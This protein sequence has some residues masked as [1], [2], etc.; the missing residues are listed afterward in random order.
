MLVALAL[1]VVAAA[2]GGGGGSSATTSGQTPNASTSGLPAPEGIV[3]VLA[4]E[5]YTE[6]SWIVPFQKETGCQVAVRYLGPGDDTVQILSASS[7]DVV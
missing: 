6:D 1:A 4:R 2:C 7:Y 5:G 3:H